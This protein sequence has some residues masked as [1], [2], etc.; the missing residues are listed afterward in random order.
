MFP[1]ISP[2]SFFALLFDISALV[3]FSKEKSK[4]VPM[5]VAASGN[6]VRKEIIKGISMG[7]GGEPEAGRC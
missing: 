1:A 4:G 3:V 7:V 2:P 6:H 5:A